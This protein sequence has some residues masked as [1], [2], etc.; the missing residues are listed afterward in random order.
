MSVTFVPPVGV[1]KIYFCF[2]L[3]CLQYNYD[4]ACYSSE[5]KIE[6]LLFEL[7]LFHSAFMLRWI[8]SCEFSTFACSDRDSSLVSMFNSK[9]I[10]V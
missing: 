10:C 5:L 3:F 8:L 1:Y 4:S 6:L 7:V 2:T 9:S